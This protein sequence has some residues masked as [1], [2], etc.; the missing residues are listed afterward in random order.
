MY[1]LNIYTMAKYILSQENF[2]WTKMSKSNLC[3]IFG[4][5]ISKSQISQ[6]HLGISVTI[7]FSCYYIKN[8][9]IAT[10]KSTHWSTKQLF[11]SIL[12]VFNSWVT[13]LWLI[14][15]KFLSHVSDFHITSDRTFDGL[16]SETIIVTDLLTI[17]KQN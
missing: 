4:Q 9:V 5:I 17:H 8:M 6:L 15:I 13:F 2:T 10:I 14:V 11:I 3:S 1:L 16:K 7:P 12:W